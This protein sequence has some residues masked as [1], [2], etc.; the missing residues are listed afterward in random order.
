MDSAP[1]AEVG[2]GFRCCLL[3]EGRSAART[4]R[5]KLIW[6][7]GKTAFGGAMTS[8]RLPQVASGG[9]RAFSVDVLFGAPPASR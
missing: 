5:R 4:A 9:Y 7:A 8:L 1:G 2:A 3:Q 6:T